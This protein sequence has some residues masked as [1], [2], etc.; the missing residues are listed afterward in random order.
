MELY[1]K[2]GTV[3]AGGYGFLLILEGFLESLSKKTKDD[4]VNENPAMKSSSFF[5]VIS[6]R[7]EV[8]SLL[9]SLTVDKKNIIEKLVSYGD[10]LDIVEANQK[11]KVHIH[12]DLPDNVVE[13]ISTFGSVVYVRTT[14]MTEQIDEI[15]NSKKSVGLVVDDASGLDI[16]FATEHD[17]AFVPFKTSWEKVDKQS[18]Y[19]K[20]SIYQKME[21]FKD[22]TEKYGWPKTSQPTLQSFSNSFKEQLQKYNYIICITATTVISGSY[23]AAIQARSLLSNEDQKRV[24]VPDLKQFGPGQALLITKAVKLIEQEYTYKQIEKRLLSFAEN[25]DT[26]GTPKN[27]VWITTG[28]RINGTLAKI[29]LFFQKIKVRPMFLLTTKTIGLKKI[30]FGDKPLSV[31]FARFLNEKYRSSNGPLELVIQHGDDSPEFEKLK[32]LLNPK[33][34]TIVQETILSPVIGIHTGP[35]TF[36]VGVL[37]SNNK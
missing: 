34:F 30:Y 21:I 16:N 22:K 12:T 26:F 10:C 11:I 36:I 33:C 25:I 32:K 37:K 13:L 7:Y 2:A 29:A 24:I 23:N 31:L 19:Q 4:G 14:D 1:K 9:E 27:I 6:H 28:G 18:S 3:D 35:G 17:I 5:Q 8:I 15:K 20:M